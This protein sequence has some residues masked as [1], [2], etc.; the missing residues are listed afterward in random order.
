MASNKRRW[1]FYTEAELGEHEVAQRWRWAHF[2][3][4]GELVASASSFHTLPA[5]VGDARGHGFSGEFTLGE[6]GPVWRRFDDWEAL[7][8]SGPAPASHAPP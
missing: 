2:D 7:S 1:R 4:D 3:P 8:A 5:A 6:E